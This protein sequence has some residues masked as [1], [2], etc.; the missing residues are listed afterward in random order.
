MFST[1]NNNI[2]GFYG[3]S[4]DTNIAEDLLAEM[5][6]YPIHTRSIFFSLYQ[7]ETTTRMV[8][9]D[10]MPLQYWV[11][12]DLHPNDCNNEYINHPHEGEERV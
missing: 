3:E 2:D 8:E 12:Y 11:C 10:R 6:S 1:K 9:N 4:F 7:A 5:L